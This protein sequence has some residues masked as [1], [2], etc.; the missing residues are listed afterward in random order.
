MAVFWP[1]VKAAAPDMTILGPGAV[2]KEIPLAPIGRAGRVPNTEDILKATGPVFDAFSYH[3]HG[4]TSK[5]CAAMGLASQTTAAV[6]L[7]ES[8]FFSCRQPMVTSPVSGDN[9]HRTLADLSKLR[10]DAAE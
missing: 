4:A 8:P 3:S 5:R 9:D 10:R 1:F 2:G 7:S 6:A